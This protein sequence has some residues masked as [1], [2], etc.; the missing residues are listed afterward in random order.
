MGT[1]TDAILFYGYCWDEEGSL[2]EDE[3]V[4]DWE[5]RYAV[6]TGVPRPSQPY[7]SRQVPRTRENNYD[8]TPKDYTPEELAAKQ[9]Y[10]DFWAAKR[11]AVEKSGVEVGTHCSYECSMPYVCIKTSEITSHRGYMSEIKSL[12]VDP[13]WN[14]MLKDFCK[15]MNIDTKDMKP[16]WWMVSLWG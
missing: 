15:K 5:A 16:K 1:S 3:E 14:A 11:K 8:G 4:D 10:H 13:E 12:D 2:W 6:A 7:P 9:E